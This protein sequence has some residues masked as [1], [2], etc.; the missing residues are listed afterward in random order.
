V[1]R[2]YG[3]LLATLGR[4]P[5]AIAVTQKAIE[6]DPLSSP[7]W[8]TLGLYL[9]RNR[10]YA[11]AHE[12]LRRAL[13]IQ[14]ESLYALNDL[15]TLE[16]VE[17]EAAQALATFRQVGD[18][19][20]RLTGIAMAEHS[21]E[22]AKESQQALDSLIANDAQDAAY[23]IAEVYAW[24]GEKDQAFAWLQRAYRQRDG[25]LSDIKFDVLLAAVRSDAR[26]G[27]MLRKMQLTR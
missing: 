18:A 22:H 23:Q 21:L 7:A 9:I 10:Q 2:R 20:F 13:E 1:Q 12:A 14:P 8:S 3:G 17:G 15:G 26:F 5:E 16:L 25:A 4:L 11:A 19:G 24:R 27:E 6:L